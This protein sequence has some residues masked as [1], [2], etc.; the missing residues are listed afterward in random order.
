MGKCSSSLGH[1][2]ETSWMRVA[3]MRT[4]C[5]CPC[6]FPHQLFNVTI[7]SANA[8]TAK[9]QTTDKP[10]Q[11][12]TVY[13]LALC[14]PVEPIDLRVCYISESEENG[15]E[16]SKATTPIK[17]SRGRQWE[18]QSRQQTNPGLAENWCDQPS[19]CIFG[20]ELILLGGWPHNAVP[21]G[22]R[23]II[24]S[25]LM[26][27]GLWQ[28]IILF[29]LRRDLRAHQLGSGPEAKS[30]QEWAAILQRVG[31]IRE[32]ALPDVNDNTIWNLMILLSTR[33]T[34]TSSLQTCVGK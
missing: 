6:E 20:G 7:L 16:V 18:L 17:S 31:E 26:K 29:H 33:K 25:V 11:F 10:V 4:P 23:A 13:R 24:Q 14:L 21:K 8:T 2:G 12:Y 1:F 19:A 28:Q 22:S 15:C 27:S 3:C 9:T 30:Q 32:S 34:C 5:H